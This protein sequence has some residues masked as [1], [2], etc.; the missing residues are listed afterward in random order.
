MDAS[1][2]LI[3]ALGGGWTVSEL[4]KTG[5]CAKKDQHW[6][7]KSQTLVATPWCPFGVFRNS[8]P[9]DF[10]NVFNAFES[11]PCGSFGR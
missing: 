11:R 6:T 5:N 2:L 7:E 4:P 10:A 9:L 8:T 3:K 1:V